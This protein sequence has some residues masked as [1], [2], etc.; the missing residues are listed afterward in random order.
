MN[1]DASFE[2]GEHCA[3][4]VEAQIAGGRFGSVDEVL[5]AGLRL[6]EEQ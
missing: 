4:F 6:L 1:K 5:R 2:F 3:S